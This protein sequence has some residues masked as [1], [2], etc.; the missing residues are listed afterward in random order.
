MRKKILG[1]LDEYYFSL[2]LKLYNID[3][4]LQCI[5]VWYQCTFFEKSS[6][7]HVHPLKMWVVQVKQ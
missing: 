4:V 7:L 1:I 2:N 5:L 3:I 6:M